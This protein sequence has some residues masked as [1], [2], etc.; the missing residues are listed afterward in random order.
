MSEFLPDL[1]KQSSALHSHLCPRQILGVQ[2]GLYGLAVLGLERPVN[3]QTALVIIETD[4]C[5]ADGIQVSTGADIGHRTLRVNDFGKI[6]AT[7]V[8]V[9]TGR[10]LRLSPRHDVR[11]RAHL[12]APEMKT[13]YYAQLHGY[14]AMPA[15]ELFNLR[16]VILK[17]SLEEILSKANVRVTCSACGD[18]VIN[19]RHVMHQGKVLCQACAGHG[20]YLST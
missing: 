8:D 13:R 5:F 19:E 16:E 20:Y 15:E 18:E 3:K 17:P 2:M 11:Q 12:Y 14:Q 7:F 9:Q 6:A 4:G 1:L 10:A